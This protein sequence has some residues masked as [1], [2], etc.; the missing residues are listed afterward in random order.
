MEQF[1]EV[2]KILKSLADTPETAPNE[3]GDLR[4][5]AMATDA[6][7]GWS[8]K[9]SL[10]LDKKASRTDLDVFEATFNAACLCVSTNRLGQAA[11]LLKRA[12]RTIMLAPC[13]SSVSPDFKEQ[14]YVMLSKTFRRKKLKPSLNPSSPRKSTY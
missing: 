13:S 8:G 5:N 10:V 1:E 11:V 12:R 7:L 14:N 6:Q 9:Q 4:V 2:S 3:Y